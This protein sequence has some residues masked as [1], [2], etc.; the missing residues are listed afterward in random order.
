MILTVAN[1]DKALHERLPWRSRAAS[2]SRWFREHVD[3]EIDEGHEVL[4]T[5]LRPLSQA[6]VNALEDA[7]SVSKEMLISQRLKR[8]HGRALLLAVEGRSSGYLSYK[9]QVRSGTYQSG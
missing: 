6:F 3:D 5:T 4:T 9:G 2:M 7:H 1:L 8:W